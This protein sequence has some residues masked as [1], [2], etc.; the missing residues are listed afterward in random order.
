MVGLADECVDS[1]AGEVTT[2]SRHCSEA[3]AVGA[4]VATNARGKANPIEVSKRICRTMAGLVRGLV[5]TDYRMFPRF[6]RRNEQRIRLSLMVVVQRQLSGNSNGGRRCRNSETGRRREAPAKPPKSRT[7]HAKL[8]RL[9]SSRCARPLQGGSRFRPLRNG[10]THRRCAAV[11]ES[12]PVPKP[13][14]LMTIASWC[15]DHS[16]PASTSPSNLLGEPGGRLKPLVFGAFFLWLLTAAGAEPPK[17]S[18]QRPVVS[19]P[20]DFPGVRYGAW[21]IGLK[22][23]FPA[24]PN[25]EVRLRMQARLLVGG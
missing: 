3:E 22:A 6:E 18:S 7:R 20:P 2:S 14:A 8:T 25:S 21:R 4:Q 12:P 15:C 13:A 16:W 1:R 17:R 9:P 10:S 24:V 5:P 19:E 11:F 23:G